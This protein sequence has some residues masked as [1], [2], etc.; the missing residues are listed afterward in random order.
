MTGNDRRTEYTTVYN[1]KMVS[2]C[3][4]GGNAISFAGQN[5]VRVAVVAVATALA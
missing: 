5:I 3:A 2:D 4:L 1:S